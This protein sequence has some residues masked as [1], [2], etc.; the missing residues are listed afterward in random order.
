VDLLRE[1]AIDPV[2]IE[3]EDGVA[4]L[5]MLTPTL[6][7]TRVV[8][9][10]SPAHGQLFVEYGERMVERG[11]GE[12][13]VFHDWFE[14]TGY[15]TSARKQLTDWSVAN[16]KHYREVHIGLR[17]KIVA[18]GINVANIPLGG[19]IRAHGS[20]PPFERAFE[21]CLRAYA[22]DLAS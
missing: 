7:C 3:D 15:E 10:M 17:S 20:R 9:N 5:W 8:G 11:P 12:L 19:L 2:S 1:R 21:K 22:P 16:R 6:Y 14:M 18:M 4:E 13:R